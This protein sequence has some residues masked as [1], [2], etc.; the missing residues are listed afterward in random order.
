MFSVPYILLASVLIEPPDGC[1]K[2]LVY[3]GLFTVASPIVFTERLVKIY[4]VRNDANHNS[5][6]PTRKDARQARK[7]QT[8]NQLHDF[9]TKY[10][11]MV[12]YFV[13]KA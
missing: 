2:D 6:K 4:Q 9:T 1:I 10:A 5:H 3:C 11:N 13:V 8:K 12:A 7:H